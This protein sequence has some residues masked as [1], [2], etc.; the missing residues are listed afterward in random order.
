M[1]LWPL[2][3]LVAACGTPATNTGA[4]VEQDGSYTQVFLHSS[5]AVFHASI[6]AA[7]DLGYTLDVADPMSGRVSGR[8]EIKPR[9]LGAQ[10]EYY[11]LRAD[12]EA[13]QAGIEGVRLRI[14]FTFT[15]HLAG[16]S[17]SSI[18]DKIVGSRSRYDAFF[19]AVAKQLG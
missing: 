2:L 4:S 16:Q 6:A 13:P 15:H 10:V 12:I 14:V 1:R 5:D 18:N 19:E 8:S 9:G 11:L 17:R 3:L 7:K